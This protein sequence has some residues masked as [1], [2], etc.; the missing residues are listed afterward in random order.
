MHAAGY[1]QAAGLAELLARLQWQVLGLVQGLYAIL[2]G[3]A[4]S[5]PPRRS[6]H[7]KVR[8]LHE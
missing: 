5:S 4:S 1:S 8:W 6:F 3:S 7:I 2:A